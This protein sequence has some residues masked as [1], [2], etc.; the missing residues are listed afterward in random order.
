MVRTLS[1]PSRRTRSSQEAVAGAGTT[2]H[3]TNPAIPQSAA[4]A[5]GP[6]RE[7]DHR[8]GPA[9][10]RRVESDRT[11]PPLLTSRRVVDLGRAT[12]TRC[13]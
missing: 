3:T 7:V 6:E 11:A 4:A 13:R 2:T 10:D 12:T 1:L 5:P 9:Y 8:A